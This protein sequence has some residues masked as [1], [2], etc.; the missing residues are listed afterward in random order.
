V[1]KPK[2]RRMAMPVSA[3]AALI[4]FIVPHAGHTDNFQSVS[5]DAAADELVIVV[6]YSGTNPDH[7]FSLQWGP[8]VDHGDGGREIVADLLDQQAQDAAKTDFT[9]TVR[10]SLASLECRPAAVTLRTAPRF[11][12]TLTV[13]ARAG[14][15]AGR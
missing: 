13:P 6:A 8:C 7:R 15:L 10:M 9:K 5:Y 12:Y 1:Q 14:S 11:Y 3:L 4:A 2:A